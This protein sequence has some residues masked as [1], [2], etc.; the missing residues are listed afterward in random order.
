MIVFLKSM[1]MLL[2]IEC[3]YFCS[4]LICQGKTLMFPP[5]MV[6]SDRD[7]RVQMGF[8]L[9]TSSFPF[10]CD[11]QVHL[12]GKCRCFLREGNKIGRVSTKR[13]KTIGGDYWMI[14]SVK[15]KHVS[16]HTEGSGFPMAIMENMGQNEEFWDSWEKNLLYKT[17]L[18]LHLGFR[19][20][21]L[22]YYFRH[23]VLIKA[24]YWKSNEQKHWH[25]V[26]GSIW[27]L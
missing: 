1:I 20:R 19:S 15:V 6:S 11:V 16:V 12:C 4:G 23:D 21:G 8:S 24:S 26:D 10:C 5:K 14:K 2:K 7:W 25:N 18:F 9:S 17:T 3:Q 27:K 22:L 13:W